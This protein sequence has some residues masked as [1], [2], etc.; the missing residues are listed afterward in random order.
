MFEDKYPEAPEGLG[1]AHGVSRSDSMLWWRFVGLLLVA[2]LAIFASDLRA[3]LRLEALAGQCKQQEIGN[4]I[5]YQEQYP[6]HLDFSS[7]CASLGLSVLTAS[8]GPW[9]F[10]WRLAYVDLGKMRVD[11]VFTYRDDENRQVYDGSGCD[12]STF[13]GCLGRGR[14]EQQ[15]RGLSAGFIT[16]R[17]VGPV[18][19]GAD[20]GL[21]LYDGRFHIS[22]A[23][24]GSHD[25]VD[26]MQFAWGGYRV[27]PYLGL[28]ARYGDFLLTARR[29]NQVSAQEP[30][31]NG[32]S[33]FANGHATQFNAGI[34]IPL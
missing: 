14:G 7:G 1:A 2:M 18:V 17:A 26:F 34:S 5:W 11:S 13:S 28:T 20:V 29:Y 15:T 22:I 16:E 19:L 12:K 8:R 30:N 32:C 21:F 9:F 10:G 31:C 25:K 6:H 23:G 24:Q 3:E 27:T 33:G 4:G